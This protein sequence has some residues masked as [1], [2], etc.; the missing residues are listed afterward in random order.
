MNPSPDE[1]S[2]PSGAAAPQAAP[3]PAAVAEPETAV[4]E[5]ATA[6]SASAADFEVLVGRWV[7][8]DSPYV[9]EI[10]SAGDDGR[11]EAAYYNPRSINVSVAKARKKNGKLE[12]FVELRDINY[13]G[14]NYRLTYEA[15]NDLLRGVYFQAV[16]QQNFDVAFRRLPST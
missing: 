1:P 15:S 3:A 4:T 11:L 9:I 5:P 8:L 14:S 16:M 12:V 10:R 2:A 13:P 6:V 7:R